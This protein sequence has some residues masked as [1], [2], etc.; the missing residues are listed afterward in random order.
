TGLMTLA[1]GRRISLLEKFSVDSWVDAV[2]RVKPRLGNMPPAALRMILDANVPKER[3][4]SLV[5]L[6]SGTAPLDPTIID[7]FQERYGLPVLVQYGAT[8]FAG[9]VA[10]WDLQAFRELYASKRGSVGRIQAR[11]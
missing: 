6:R 7:A 9:S 4:A 2:E 8:E 3:I 11:I 10:G 5:A 1:E